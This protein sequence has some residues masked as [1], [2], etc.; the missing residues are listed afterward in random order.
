MFSSIKQLLIVLLSF[1][2]SLAQNRT[3]CVSL[4][5]KPCMVRPTFIDLNPV[6]L[7]YCPFM[8]TLDGFNGSCNALSPKKCV[9]EETRYKC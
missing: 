7:K 6:E 3:K 5:E 1:S 9:P 8:I 2:E 4:N